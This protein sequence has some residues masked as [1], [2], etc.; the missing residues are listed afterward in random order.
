M[1]ALIYVHPLDCY[2]RDAY[3]LSQIMIVVKGRCFTVTQEI[4]RLRLI[5]AEPAE[6]FLDVPCFV[7][8][9]PEIPEG[10]PPPTDTIIRPSAPA[11]PRQAALAQDNGSVIGDVRAGRPVGAQQTAPPQTGGRST[12]AAG[13]QDI[14]KRSAP[15]HTIAQSTCMSYGRIAD[16]W[17]YCSV[18]ALCIPE[19]KR[20]LPPLYKMIHA[21]QRLGDI[22]K[23]KTGK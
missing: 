14:S 8:D 21:E 23:I 19:V 12:L 13:C 6:R 2:Q 20:S 11:L 16:G 3:Q 4:K 18:R 5:G 10:L 1:G 22:S 9:P 17:P 7:L 15:M